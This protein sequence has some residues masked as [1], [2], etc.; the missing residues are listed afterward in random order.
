MTALIR[1]KR[2]ESTPEEVLDFFVA[3]YGQQVLASLPKQGL[4]PVLWVLAPVAILGGGGVIYIVLKKWVRR[5]RR[6]QTIT[7]GEEESKKYQRQLEKE[8]EEFTNGGF[9]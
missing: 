8:L 4:N 5:G 3:Q 1:E 9:R 6:S 7:M 2:N